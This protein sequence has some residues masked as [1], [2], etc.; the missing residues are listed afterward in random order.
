[1]KN[2]VVE[3]LEKG[4]PIINKEPGNSMTPIL[5]SKE[6]VILEPIT[7]LEGI[8]KGD[9]VFAKIRGRYYT[10]LV[11]G[12]DKE[13]GILLGNNHGHV[14]GWTKKVYAKAHRIPK[15]WQETNEKLNQ[16]LNDIFHSESEESW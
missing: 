15:E 3:L 8:E 16:Y 4:K 7:T 10:H 13:R 5:T 9:I 1:M 12:I 6:P 11:H 14:Q 2:R